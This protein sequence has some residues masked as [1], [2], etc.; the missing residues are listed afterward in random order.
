MGHARRRRL[1][2]KEF[3]SYDDRNFFL[4]A[5]SYTHPH[6]NAKGAEVLDVIFK[7]CHV[8]TAHARSPP[9]PARDCVCEPQATC[10]DAAVDDIL[11]GGSDGCLTLLQGC[12]GRCTTGLSQTTLS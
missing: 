3:V 1:Q 4:P 11:G 9:C 2:V 6:G 5:V 12:G 8:F 10:S 7:V